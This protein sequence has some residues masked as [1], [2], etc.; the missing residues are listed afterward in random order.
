[1]PTEPGARQRLAPSYK[2]GVLTLAVICG[3][4][5]CT[6]LLALGGV[7]AELMTGNLLLLSV[8]F[9]AGVLRP[10]RLGAYA[11][12]IGPFLLGALVAGIASNGRHAHLA[13]VVGYPVEWAFI[14]AATVLATFWT[15]SVSGRQA[16]DVF[17]VDDL[18]AHEPTPYWARIVIVALLAFAMGIHNALMRK[19]GVPDVATNVL[20]LTLTGLVSDSRLAGGGSSRW[21]RRLGSILLFM[22]GAVAGAWL[23]QLH[24]AA[25]LIAAS[26]LFTLALWPLVRGRPEPP[27]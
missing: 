8:Q 20:T 19:H 1:M 16:E 26:A 13:R 3:L 18:A 2:A 12:A 21:R 7:F 10:E 14:V 22:L 27:P 6:C 24:V 17:L 5:D 23:L 25:P 15:S 11:G 9:G 4:I